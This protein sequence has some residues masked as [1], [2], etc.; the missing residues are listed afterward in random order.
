MALNKKNKYRGDIILRNEFL[1]G[2]F[3]RASS[4]YANVGPD[5]FNYF[6]ERL[7]DLSRVKKDDI[8]LDIAFG[9]GASLFPASKAVGD[10][11]KIIG[12]DFSEGMVLET[13][14]VIVELGIKNI[15][16]SKMDAENIELPES[17]FDKVL[18]GLSI[19]F[20]S[21]FKRSLE[22]MF[23]VLKPNGILGIS[24]WK[25]KVSKPGIISRVA[26][27]YLPAANQGNSD[28]KAAR[29]DFGD[30][31]FLKN[32]LE[33]IGFKN[34]NIINEKRMFYYKDCSEWWNEQWSHA[35]RATFE[36]IE[37]QGSE[38][39]IKFKNEMF[40]ELEKEYGNDRIPYDADVL[41][42]RATK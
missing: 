39:L 27:K 15:E 22:E 10:F 38:M 4:S 17:T 40:A 24:T 30:E 20:F 6:G 23:R 41:V 11:G 7:I 37:K 21:D 13:R 12:I 1:Q 14:N 36:M 42:T 5:Y 26:P 8:V 33:G 3:D 16:V 19:Q 9:R 34:V 29:P 32:T 35:G 25:K 31:E 28:M 18:C 2:V